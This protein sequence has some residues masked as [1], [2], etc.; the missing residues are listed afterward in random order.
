[1]NRTP[2]IDH[3]RVL[4]TAL[5]VLHH[6]AL[7]YG[8]VGAWYLRD[9]HEG[10]SR[11][12]T[13]FCTLNQAFFMGF[14]FLLAGY[15]TPAAYDRRG[16]ARYAIDRLRRLGLPLLA[17]ACVLDPFTVALAH[18]NSFTELL[19]I[20]WRRTEHGAFSSGPLWFVETLLIFAGFYMIWR[21]I[22]GTNREGSERLPGH[23]ALLLAALLVGAAAFLLRL[24]FPVG[25]T[26]SNLQFG[27][28]SSYIVL[29]AVGIMAARGSWLERVRFP[30]VWRWLC[31]A[32]LSLAMLL[33]ADRLQGGDFRGGWSVKAVI[34][35]F[36]EPFFAWGVILGLLYLFRTRFSAPGRWTGFLAARAYTIYVIHPPVVVAVTLLLWRWH[37]PGL[38]EFVVAGALSCCLCVLLS[39]VLV[40]LGTVFANARAQAYR[41]GT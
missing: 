8:A 30:L 39:T 40:M 33:A 41:V 23:V 4:L 7:V 10:S 15:F 1:M 16:P 14:F 38:I 22:A 35:A 6:T 5:V 29:F 32:V 28:F 9:A 2:F 27:Y 25:E 19:T 13:L 12:L 36:F 26:V 11:V 24:A 18:A 20:W 21:A 37:Q 3:I 34:Y 31:I 17:Y